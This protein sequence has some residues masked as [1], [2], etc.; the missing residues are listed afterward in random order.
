[1]S[2]GIK[3]ATAL[4]LILFLF[5]GIVPQTTVRAKSIS[6]NESIVFR[7]LINEMG[8]NTAA[9]CGVLANMEYESNFRPTMVGD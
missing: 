6:T 9:A 5:T 8:F 2:E 1:M 4:V 7:Y 3:R